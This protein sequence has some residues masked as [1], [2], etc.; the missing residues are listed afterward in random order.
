LAR[1]GDTVYL[2]GDFRYLGPRLHGLAKLDAAGTPDLGFPA[3]DG[4]V[5]VVEPDGAGADRLYR[6]AGDDLLDGR[7]GNDVL[8]GGP[9]ADRLIGGPGADT[10]NASDGTPRD[11]VS[12]GPGRDTVTADPGDHV[13]S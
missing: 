1:D 7:A 8:V 12:C 11:R 10:L 4:Y 13:G 5:R 9:G 3:V 6:D 2:D